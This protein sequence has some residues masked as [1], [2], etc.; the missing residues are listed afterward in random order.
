MYFII[1]V[2]AIIVIS[3]ISNFSSSVAILLLFYSPCFILISCKIVG[4]STLIVYIF[5]DFWHLVYCIYLIA[6]VN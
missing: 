3:I 4:L 5:K 2:I 6:I 1:I